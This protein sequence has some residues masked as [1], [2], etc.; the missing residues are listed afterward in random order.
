[1]VNT[2]RPNSVTAFSQPSTFQLCFFSV[3]TSI[4]KNNI[5]PS[6]SECE[7]LF[8]CFMVAF[9]W[10]LFSYIINV[11]IITQK[12]AVKTQ[13]STFLRCY[14][15]KLRTVNHSTVFYYEHASLSMFCGLKM[16]AQVAFLFLWLCFKM[17]SPVCFA[18][19]VQ[20]RLDF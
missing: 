14:R 5:R 19:H 12:P 15:F 8:F 18:L 20:V 7:G 2:S 9:V 1:M 4:N 13:R 6:N 3:A 17:N 16:K 11:N 10:L